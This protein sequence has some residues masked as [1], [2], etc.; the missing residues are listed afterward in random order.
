MRLLNKYSGILMLLFFST[1]LM[2]QIEKESSGF[3]EVKLIPSATIEQTKQKA[4]DAAK[5]NAIESAFGSVLMEGNSLYTVNKQEGTKTEFNQVFNSI[6]DVYVNGDW[7]KDLEQPVVERVIKGDDIYYT[8]KVKGLIRELKNNPAKF[9][10]K[11]LSCED[12][13]CETE[14]FN[15]GQDFY[16]YFKAPNSGY[17]AVYLDIPTEHTTYRLL[18]YKQESNVGSAAVKADVEY[19]YFSPKK[20]DPKKVAMVD[21]LVWSLTD[22]SM[23]ETNKLFVLYRPELPLEKPILTAS[24]SGKVKTANDPKPLEIPLSLKSEDFQVWLQQLRS[25]NKDIQ[26]Q[27]LYVT[28]KP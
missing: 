27:N 15:N 16:L 6:S 23:P 9:S 1:F 28:I 20:A 18:P 22:K 12:K 8:A 21:E 26:L 24:K 7:I 19:I 14:F 4:I 5:I 10:I 11:A 17:I 3:A 25:R 13:T 2:A